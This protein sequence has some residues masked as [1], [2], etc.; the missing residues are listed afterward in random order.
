MSQLA[1]RKD[2][3]MIQART[4]TLQIPSPHSKIQ[5]L[6]FNLWLCPNITEIVAAFGTKF[7]KTTSAAA[8][9][10]AASWIKEGGIY[11]W[12]GPIYSQTKLGFR[13]M[14]RI[15]PPAPDT[16]ANES[17]GDMS[18]LL[19]EQDTLIDFKSG[20]K[21]EDLEGEG[22]DGTVIDEAAKQKEQVYTSTKTTHT[23][24]RGPIGLFSTPLGKNWFYRRFKEAEDHMLWSIKKGI[25]PTKVA[26]KGPSILNPGVT[27]EAVA[28]NQRSMPD[29]LFRQYMLAEFLDAGSVFV[30]HR[31]C[32]YTDEIPYGAKVWLHPDAKKSEVVFGVD[33][34]K[35]KDFTVFIALE[36]GKAEKEDSD[37][38]ERVQFQRVVGF[39]RFQNVAYIEAVKELGHFAR[40]FS[41]VGL[42]YHDKTGI[43][44][45][46]DEMLARTPLPFHGVTFTNELKSELVNQLI[47]RFENRALFIPN[48]QDLLSELDAYEVT[49]TETGRMKYSAPEG[50]H[51]DIVTALFLANSAASEYA[52]DFE[53]SVLEDMPKNQTALD[54]LYSELIDDDD[55]LDPSVHLFK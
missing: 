35:H 36:V 32:L 50:E 42:I 4:N 3:S 2:T 27:K 45:A 31:E 18:I 14:K 26:V 19:K 21:P 30:N 37:D 24:T 34:A 53:I 1:R 40:R 47:L 48:S 41:R 39:A 29:R 11:R 25:P 44:I 23:F 12:V 43:G 54:D 9:L 13:N 7:G 46:L 49:S 15:L 10:S 38:Y 52:S 17:K 22:S 33:W 51:D 6:L 8:G 28:E 5:A 20:H 55:D 16:K